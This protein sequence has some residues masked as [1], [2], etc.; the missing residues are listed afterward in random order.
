ME[1]MII[2]GYEIL[3]VRKAV[4]RLRLTVVPPRGQL[5]ITAPPQASQAQLQ[6][7]ITDNLD[8][9]RKNTARFR[10]NAQRP[11]HQY[12]SGEVIRLFGQPLTLQV[13]HGPGYHAQQNGNRLLLT[14]PESAGRESCQQVIDHWYAEQLKQALP[15][16]IHRWEGVLGVH[17]KKWKI[18]PMTSRWGSCNRN[19]GNIN[20]NL[21][22]AAMPKEFLEYVVVHELC[23]FHVA[24]H[25]QEFWS[26]VARCLPDWQVRRN[27]LN[28]Y[29]EDQFGD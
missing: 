19:T 5:R 24:A 18:H 25:N 2:A 26:Y 27:R 7:F 4:K 6:Q 10:Q 20:L 21:R 3:V 15:P 13:Q 16:L 11:P 23:H 17:A 14:V 29:Y 12:C 1:Q 8:W 9:I 22:L 28:S